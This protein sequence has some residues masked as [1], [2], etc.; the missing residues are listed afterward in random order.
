ML[1][2]KKNK[3]VSTDWL[4]W[5]LVLTSSLSSAVWVADSMHEVQPRKMDGPR[6]AALFAVDEDRHCWRRA[7][8]SVLECWLPVWADR[9]CSRRGLC[10]PVDIVCTRFAAPRVTSATL[11]ARGLY[12]RAASCRVQV[13]N[14]CGHQQQLS[15]A[16]LKT[17]LFSTSY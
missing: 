17:F 1:F 16:I 7:V 15:G 14:W 2:N 13:S 8:T 4:Y 9:W 12:G 10:V 6:F 5:V 11:G 3:K